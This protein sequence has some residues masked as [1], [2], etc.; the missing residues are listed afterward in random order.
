MKNKIYLVTLLI[1][2]VLTISIAAAEKSFP[3]FESI[4]LK[5]RDFYFQLRHTFFPSNESSEILLVTI[6]D[7]TLKRLEKS[8]PFPRSIYAE[9][10]NRLKPYAPKAIGFDL[11][12][13]GK[14]LSVESDVLFSAALKD[15]GNV[16]IASHLSS[17]GEIGPDTNISNTAWQVG[18]VDKPRDSDRVIRESFF[19]FP[20]SGTVLPSWEAAIFEK[21]IGELSFGD[22][23]KPFVIDY[24]L[25]PEEFSHISLWRLLEGSV[26]ANELQHKIILIGPTAEVF[27]DFHATPLGLMPGLAVNANALATLMRSQFF[28]EPPMSRWV[29]ALISFFSIWLALLLGLSE[30][31]KK[32]CLIILFLS[33]SYLALGFWLFLVYQLVDFWLLILVIFAVFTAANFFRYGTLWVLDDQLKRASQPDPL[34]GFYTERFLRLRLKR[35]TNPKNLNLLVIEIDPSP[36]PN[37]LIVT[38]S[39]VLRSSVR[40]NELVC[41]YGD[42]SFVII[43][44]NTN[45]DDVSRFGEKI[46]KAVQGKIHLS[47]AI[48]KA[49]EFLRRGPSND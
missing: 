31:L 40:K 10:I 16:V 24:R 37:H 47:I 35:E 32:S 39:Q 18:I 28:S 38:A 33:V 41:R 26:L 2:I 45:S 1:S 25:K 21:A 42:R 22:D 46:K 19:S 44:P 8:W 49:E 7:E 36:E 30:S 23:K 27:H 17:A 48:V 9:A 3:I 11:I 6:D 43:L 29:L 15:A 34:T 14:D 4:N 13:S 12:F 20:I 5:G